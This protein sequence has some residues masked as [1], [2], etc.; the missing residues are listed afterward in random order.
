MTAT[1]AK[2]RELK[3]KHQDTYEKW[4]LGRY[5][6]HS[7]EKLNGKLVKGVIE[8]IE[9]IGNSVYGVVVL[10]LNNGIE[11]TVSTSL[12]AYRPRKTDVNVV[13]IPNETKQ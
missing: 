4:W 13:Q 5:I 11:W 8:N 6:D 12:N 1:T 10:T 9:Y 2:G 3:Q 7:P